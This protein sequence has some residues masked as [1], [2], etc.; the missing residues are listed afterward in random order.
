MLDC[1]ISTEAIQLAD[2]ACVLWAIQD[3]TQRKATELEL[4][5]AI[6]AVMK[7][8]SWFSRSVLD[9]LA[10]LRAPQVDLT[11]ATLDD[12]TAREREVLALICQGMDD[13]RIARALD[14][15]GNTV[16]NHVAR[17]YGK[18]GVNRRLAAVTWARARGFGGEGMVTA[19]HEQESAA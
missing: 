15:S 6:E 12:L 5:E 17:I 10:R 4:V 2:D 14:L 18:I 19:R 9:K 11:G 7:D 8:T 3:I 13:K 16:R 1:L